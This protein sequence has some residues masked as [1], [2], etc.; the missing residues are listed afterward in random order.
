MSDSGQDDLHRP[1]GLEEEKPGLSQWRRP[2][3][4][5]VAIG[6]LSLAAYV[7]I[8][9]RK[10]PKKVVALGTETEIRVQ[11]EASST[12]T[13]AA[14]IDTPGS[15]VKPLS[16]LE[17][18][19]SD[20]DVASAPVDVPGF[21]P[22]VQPSDNRSPWAPVADLV[23]PSE[24]GPLPRMSQ[25]G[26]RPLD[27]YSESSG[28]IGANRVAIVVGGLGISQTGTQEAIRKLPSQVTLAFSPFGNSLQRWMQAA[29]KAGHEVALQLPME[30]LGYP[31]V[32]PG[33]RTLTSKAS[34][35][36]NLGNLRWSLGRMTN[37]PVVMNYLGAG[38]NG[39]E[40]ALRPILNE[41]RQRGLAYFD[42]GSIETSVA[43]QVADDLRLPHLQGHAV[44]DAKRDD[45][46]IR[47]RLAAIEGLARQQG[48]AVATATAFP[49]SVE[50]ISKWVAD[51]Q[52]RGI[53]VVP[54]SNLVKDYSR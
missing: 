40:K 45:A 25:G 4:I 9:A 39:D 22:K 44:V 27:A 43:T 41:L 5:A 15:S 18:L 2:A 33:P 38:M 36:E 23:E 46:S 24:F 21:K 11:P 54:L 13:P 42:D 26:M 17:P 28:S 47:S 1:L 20:N 34:L 16:P 3:L 53:V 48:Y 10:T 35:G 32:N 7:F 8:D 52:R 14:D 30:P 49:E 6:L 31:A 29:R 19:D 50:R 37:Y 12:N 51:A